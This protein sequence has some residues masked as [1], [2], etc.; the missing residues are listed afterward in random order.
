M[1]F[2]R[3]FQKFLMDVYSCS[4]NQTTSFF[5]FNIVYKKGII[6]LNFYYTSNPKPKKLHCANPPLTQSFSISR[7]PFL[8]HLVMLMATKKNETLKTVRMHSRLQY[9]HLISNL[10]SACKRLQ[11]I[12]SSISSWSSRNLF[13]I[14]HSS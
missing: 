12:L 6:S 10:Q 2:G 4:F 1:F 11:E 13:T 3:L 14:E 8:T 5:L 7:R 9:L